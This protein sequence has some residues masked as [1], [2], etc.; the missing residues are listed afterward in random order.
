MTV[1]HDE[2]ESRFFVSLDGDEADL[3]YT[4][5]GPKLIDLQH[6]YVPE[7]ARGHG[8]ADALAEAAFAYAREHGDRVVPSCPFVRVWLRRHPEQ[9]KLLDPP[10][11]ESLERHARP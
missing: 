2:K 7:S 9:C 8:V 6:T 4:R 3:V 11:A 5:I 10:F 1:E